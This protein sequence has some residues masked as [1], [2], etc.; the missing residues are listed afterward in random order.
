MKKKKHQS[1]PLNFNKRKLIKL[2]QEALIADN[3]P[4][5]VQQQLEQYLVKNYET[6]HL[7]EQEKKTPRLKILPYSFIT[8][9]LIL[10]F[11]AVWPIFKYYLIFPTFT[12]KNLISPIPLEQVLEVNPIVAV[13][14]E[15][16]EN[17]QADEFI[18]AKIPEPQIVAEDLD[19]TDL[20]NWFKEETQTDV[21]KQLD[22]SQQIEYHLEIP[23][24]DIYNAKVIFGSNDLDG[25]LIQ[26]AGTA[27]PG[28]KG[29]TVIFGHSVLRQFYNPKES[30]PN[31]YISIF[32]KI[33]TLEKGDK[34]YLKTPKITYTYM[35]SDKT[36]VKPEDTY[37]LKQNYN[38][39]NLK[40]VTCVPEGTYLRRGV[41]TAQ[42]IPIKEDIIETE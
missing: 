24:V 36:E 31:R 13:K 30:N 39:R 1:L 25:S 18:N 8:L 29:T 3:S 40:L 26:Y 12:K 2:Y 22:P 28:E 19:F 11:V 23:A 37:I 15:V 33:M 16:N 10:I 27:K 41:V 7:F 14:A 38:V 20:N 17:Y 21:N 32:S 42:L 4:E 35:V 5:Y 34:I 9:G 6:L